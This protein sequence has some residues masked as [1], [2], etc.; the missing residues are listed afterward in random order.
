MIISIT[1]INAPS[2][3]AAAAKLTNCVLLDTPFA[4]PK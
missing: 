2:V 3:A 1:A 4:R